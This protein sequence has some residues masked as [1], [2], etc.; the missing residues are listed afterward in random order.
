MPLLPIITPAQSSPEVVINENFG[1]LEGAGSFGYRPATSVGLTWGYYGAHWGD[2]DVP[3]ATVT[4]AASATNYLTCDPATGVVSVA[5]ATTD[6]ATDRRI[7]KIVT[8][9]TGV[10]SWEDH[11]FGPSG[12]LSGSAGGGGG[13]GAALSDAA[14]LALGLA[15]PGVAALAS[16]ADHVHPLPGGYSCAAW[17]APAYREGVDQVS[18]AKPSPS[19]NTVPLHGGLN[20]T[21]TGTATGRAISNANAAGRM[22]RIGAVSAAAAG[23]LAGFRGGASFFTSGGGAMGGA[24]LVVPFLI[25]DAALVGDA[26]LFIGAS[27]TTSAPSNAD[28][29]TLTNHVGIGAGSADTT[30]R[31]FAAGTALG[32]PIDLGPDFPVAASEGY[33]LALYFPRDPAA[34]GFLVGWHVVRLGTTFQA[35]GVIT[36]TPGTAAPGETTNLT[37][38]AWRTNNTTAAAVG[39]D[40]GQ[41]YLATLAD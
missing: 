11:R 18:F 3:A 23:S 25:S 26:R 30:L 35:S 34:A 31:I 2:T 33:R 38:Q 37:F 27:N 10:V 8:G 17:T 19:S 5:I 7:A 14:P 22:R 15:A 6:W 39:L 16:R 13:G 9:A 41:I 21:A 36:G 4:L 1:S 40:V 12:A 20:L 32:A 29:S 24:L 28:P